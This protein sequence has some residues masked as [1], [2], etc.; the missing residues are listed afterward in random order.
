MAEEQV[1]EN[2][3]Q[4]SLMKLILSTKPSRFRVIFSLIVGLIA[5]AAELILPLLTQNII[6]QKSLNFSWNIVI[7]AVIVF[8]IQAVFNGLTYYFLI[9]V[10]NEVVA[11]IRSR[12]WTKIMYLP[13]NFFEQNKTGEIVSRV[14]NDTN[15]IKDLVSE[16]FLDFVLGTVTVIGAVTILVFLDWQLTL[17]MLA[18]IP[19]TAIVIVPLGKMIYNIS[20]KTQ[21]KTAEF[22]SSITQTLA[23]TRL[24][25]SSNA[26]DYEAKH[27][28]KDINDLFK[29][30]IKEAKIDSF[31]YPLV[32]GVLM[33]VIIG[34][35]AYGG[36]RVTNGTLTTG[37][38][39]AFIIYLFQI[40][41]PVT[42]FGTFF[43]QVQKA[44]GATQRIMQILEEDTEQLDQGLDVEMKKQ[45]IK[46]DDVSFKYNDDKTILRNI[47][48]TAK[49]NE[50]TAL[51][52]PS[53]SGKST[54]FALIERFYKP[55]SGA[56]YID[57]ILLDDI[58]LAS[59]RK[60]IG[61]V[62]QEN[63][64][65]A[66]TVRENL[67]YGLDRK[68]TDKELWK[69]VEQAYAKTIIEKLPKGFNTEIGERGM[70]LSGGERQ[71][72]AIARAFLRD[73]KILLLD[74]A[75]ASLDAQSEAVVQEALANLMKNRTTFVIAHRLATIVDADKIIF[76]D[77]GDITGI[78]THEE[79]KKTHK[80]YASFAEQQLKK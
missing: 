49:T 19:L 20:I 51:V 28:E 37:T 67:T 3:P 43:A 17:I 69:V 13:I 4:Y 36:Y 64:L 24:V 52:G 76:V 10:G 80:L 65:F 38:L 71:R 14:V 30:G 6:D 78:G 56:I 29:F 68:V 7:I 60:Q 5:T 11:K 32:T 16:R 66:T 15:I 79:L 57:D 22:T 35:V 58:S 73:P 33:M 47:S 18:A 27:G 1:A 41:M 25:K 61:Y 77:N 12:L 26:E 40:I 39:I 8:V 23:E 63:S 54:I 59:W 45:T 62:P 2:Q 72:I 21:K 75:T 46:F 55:V 70:K 53:G 50:I 48:F 44:K 9:Y 74:E 34:I 42:Q 31:L